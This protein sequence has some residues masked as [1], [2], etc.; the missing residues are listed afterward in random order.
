[1]KITKL[2]KFNGKTLSNQGGILT[3]KYDPLNPLDLPPYTIRAKFKS[4]AVPKR[5]V[6]TPVE[7]Q[8]DVYDITYQQSRWQTDIFYG[9][10]KDLLEVLGANTTG[11]TNMSFLFSFCTSLEKVALFDTSTV[12][13]FGQMFISCTSLTSIPN[14]D[15]SNATNISQI[16]QRCTALIEIPQYM[17]LS[18][19]K[20]ISEMFYYCSSLKKVGTIKFGNNAKWADHLFEGCSS[21]QT[22]DNL[23]LDSVQTCGQ[24]FKDCT[25]LKHLDP[26][27]LNSE[28]LWR[29]EEAFS[30][31]ENLDNALEIYNALKDK[32]EYEEDRY[33]DTFLDAGIEAEGGL[34]QLRKI[35]YTWGGLWDNIYIDFK[36]SDPDYDPSVHQLGVGK[37]VTGEDKYNQASKA[38]AAEWTKDTKSEDNVWRWSVIEGTN[39]SN[40]FVYGDGNGSGT[41]MLSNDTIITGIPADLTYVEGGTIESLRETARGWLVGHEI[42]PEDYVPECEIIELSLTKATSISSIIGTNYWYNNCLTGSIPELNSEDLRNMSYAF[43]RCWNVTSVGDVFAPKCDSM[44][45]AYYC[46]FGL[47]E[48]ANVMTVG[49]EASLANMCRGCINAYKNSIENAYFRLNTASSDYVNTQNCFKLCGVK[50]SADSLDNIPQSWGGNLVPGNYIPIG[51]I[52]LRRSVDYVSSDMTDLTSEID[53]DD[54][55]PVSDVDMQYIVYNGTTRYN[56]KAIEYIAENIS[57]LYP[58]WHILT[59]DDT[60]YMEDILLYNPYEYYTSKWYTVDEQNWN[61]IFDIF[62]DEYIYY[63]DD[64]D[65]CYKISDDKFDVL[66]LD[67]EDLRVLNVERDYDCYTTDSS[68]NNNTFYPIYLVKDN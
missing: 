21:L 27:I 38:F 39:L 4:G 25:N 24:I 64:W 35:P 40:A 36:F 48:L 29:F 28:D 15:F 41:P 43:S 55:I 2:V 6:V 19:A 67:G 46:M 23:I 66:S 49:E 42:D 8:P 16:F 60:E 68:F 34:E 26:R 10:N 56:K 31:C 44:Q 3:L 47:E 1:M 5:G 30:G 50:Y 12:T 32:R 37:A 7:G 51:N 17:D 20:S 58:G 53:K 57:T 14:F 54:P 52:L 11:V 61:K 62:N 65:E 63:D 33:K 22:V 59:V 18:S 9:V 13:D 45:N